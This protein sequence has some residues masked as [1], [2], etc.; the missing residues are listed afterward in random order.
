[1]KKLSKPAKAK[2]A[3]VLYGEKNGLFKC[4]NS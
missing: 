4:C 2:K 3:V 1:M